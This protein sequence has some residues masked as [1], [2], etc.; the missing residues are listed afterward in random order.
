M[1]DCDIARQAVELC[2]LESFRHESHALCG[3]RTM[4]RIERDDSC[5]LLATMLKRVEPKMRYLGGVRMSVNPEDSTH[6]QT[7][8]SKGSGSASDASAGRDMM[9]GIAS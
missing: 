6:G 5:R 9:F 1:T 2:R 8:A 7:P 4:V 3:A